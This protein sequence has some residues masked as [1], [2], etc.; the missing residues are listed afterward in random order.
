M[1]CREKSDSS[2]S[3]LHR[4]PVNNLKIDRSFVSRIGEQGENQELVETIVTLAHQLGM[5]A[6]A[7][8]VETLQQ[9]NQLKALKCEQAQGYLFSKPLERESAEALISRYVQTNTIDGVA[10]Y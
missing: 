3:Y 9:L 10:S 4:F 8:G 2:L 6:I 7:E 1:K 5:E